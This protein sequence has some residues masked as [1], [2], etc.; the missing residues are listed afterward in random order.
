MTEYN[1]KSGLDK[2]KICP[3]RATE[4]TLFGGAMISKDIDGK[5]L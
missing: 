5:S 2:I 3:G 1:M 4:R